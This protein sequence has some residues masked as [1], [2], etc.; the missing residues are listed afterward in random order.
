[1][2]LYKDKASPLQS[3]FPCLGYFPVIWIF[4]KASHNYYLV[5]L[6]NTALPLTTFCGVEKCLFVSK[7]QRI[8]SNSMN[9]K[10]YYI[11][12]AS[13]LMCIYI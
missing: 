7:E 12:A 13:I 9:A 2:A 10:L 6:G 11:Y 3:Y 4:K 8:L 5:I 1:M